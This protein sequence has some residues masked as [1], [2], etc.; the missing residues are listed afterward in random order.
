[1]DFSHFIAPVAASDFIERH[2]GQ[3]PLHIPATPAGKPLLIDWPRLNALLSIAPHWTEGNLK[4]VLNSRPVSPEFY[5]DR[6]E[7][8]DGTVSRA[9][10]AKIGVFLAMGASLVA[11][12][13]EN[14][15]P[16][17]AVIT[18]MLA[19]RFGA[20]SNANIYCSFAGIQAFATHCD[21][22]EV[23]ALQCH[24]TKKWRFYRNRADNPLTQPSGGADVQQMIDQARGPVAM[25]VLMQPGDLLYVPRGVYHDAI[26][27]S[28]ESLHVTFA[29]A[30]HTG[31]LLLRL[32]AETAIE[33]SSF[34]AYLPDGRTEDRAAL[35]R[36]LADLA[37][38][39]ATIAASPLLCDR[40]IDA[41]RML[42]K[43]RHTL[44]LPMRPK[45]HSF[46]R[47]D[48]PA[49][50]QSTA[51][52][53][54]LVTAGGRRPVGTAFAI[55]EWALARPAFSAEEIGARFAHIPAPERQRTIDLMV[56]EQLFIAYVPALG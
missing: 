21:L 32:L 35:S 38:Q 48:R 20:V 23:F 30:P 14:I 45:L 47:T 56:R 6:I 7:T 55:V 50:I 29:V 36:H 25:E 52:G 11:N 13:V 18:D 31:R 37:A 54:V 39:L 17:L 9:D 28:D 27:T 51:A 49:D 53:M 8:L 42:A 33:Q 41:Q 16:E 10:P 2:F 4:L 24:G 26:A 22:H 3:S 34:R 19:D 15:A 46:A 40:V 5:M 43:P 12:D 44:T 1:M